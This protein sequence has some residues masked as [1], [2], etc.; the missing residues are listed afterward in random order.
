[1]YEEQV[2]VP[3]IVVGPG[4][5]PRTIDEPVSLIDVG[6]TVLDLFGEATP[7]HVMGQSLV[8]LLAG[9]DVELSRPIVVDAGRRK[10]AL[11]GRDGWKVIRNIRQRTTE[12]YDLGADPG[13][14]TNLVDTRPDE[15]RARL[16]AL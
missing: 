5:A 6:P 8:P 7:G 2:R 3:M 16:D 10:Q 4:V 11:I 15:A 1:V 13:E 9:R 14:L 12:A